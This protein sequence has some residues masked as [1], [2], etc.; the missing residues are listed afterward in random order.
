MIKMIMQIFCNDFLREKKKTKRFFFS[1]YLYICRASQAPTMA[2]F[3]RV[4]EATRRTSASFAFGSSARLD[5]GS[6]DDDDDHDNL[7]SLQFDAP[8]LPSG[9]AIDGG[10]DD[11]DQTD[12]N[13]DI[14]DYD[15]DDDVIDDD[16]LDE[17]EMYKAVFDDI[18]SVPQLDGLND[19]FAPPPPRS[20]RS[21]RSRTARVCLLF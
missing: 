14:H 10:S 16:E 19:K 18:E 9:V 12:N 15:I 11:G 17:D 1:D 13:S 3:Y 7:L 2:E 5:G 21:K 8:L 20:S 4:S 6:D